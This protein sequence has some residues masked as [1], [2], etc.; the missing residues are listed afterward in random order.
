MEA[1]A[2][3]RM[4]IICEKAESN[5]VAIIQRHEADFDHLRE[6]FVSTPTPGLQVLEARGGD[7]AT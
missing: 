7:D 3:G 4:P 6:G 5:T 2:V 1:W